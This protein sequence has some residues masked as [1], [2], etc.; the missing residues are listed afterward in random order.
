ML[1]CGLLPGFPGS[2]WIRWIWVL[3]IVMTANVIWDWNGTLL[4]DTEICVETLNTVL[5][6]RNVLPVSCEQYR[7]IFCFP[8][9]DYYRKIGLDV[10]DDE[11]ERISIEFHECYRELSRQA[12]LREGAVDVLKELTGRGIVMSIVSASNQLLLERMLVERKIDPY[13]EH[14]RGLSDLYAE[15]KSEVGRE[16]MATLR[17]TDGRNMFVGDTIHDYEVACEMNCDCVLMTGGHQSKT[18]L[19]T[20]GCAVVD[21]MQEVV[22]ALCER[23]D[24]GQG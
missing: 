18:R 11:W 21:D 16:L 17:P 6:A 12:K 15:S 3:L 20:C 1:Y 8:V 19:A 5:T 22:L 13:F 10:S 9:R 2:S 24:Q 4:D 14:V 23:F 7:D